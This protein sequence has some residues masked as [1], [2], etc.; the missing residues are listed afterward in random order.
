MAVNFT[1]NL[2]KKRRSVRLHSDLTLADVDK[3]RTINLTK[4]NLLGVVNGFGDFLGMASPFTMRY[5]VLMRKLFLL[6]EPLTWDMPIPDSYRDE[7]IDLMTETLMNGSLLFP[8][9]ARP[10]KALDGKGP[11]I[12][13]C[14]DYGE[15]GYDA[16]VYLRWE[17]ETGADRPYAARLLICKARVPPLQGLTVPRG[18]WTYLAV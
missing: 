9:C 10:S 8:R 3:L 1:L 18:M 7:W 11:E 6:E 2:S 17:L 5:K 12:I 16:R 15:A 14:S 4:R 13:G